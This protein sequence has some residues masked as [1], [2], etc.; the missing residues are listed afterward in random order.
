MSVV[1]ASQLDAG[2]EPR[3]LPPGQDDGSP[4]VSSTQFYSAGGTWECTPVGCAIRDRS[5]TL[6][7]CSYC[8]DASG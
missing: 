8:V 7:R 4:R 2:L 6:R 1:R 3:G 5:D